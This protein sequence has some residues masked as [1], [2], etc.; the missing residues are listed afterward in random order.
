MERTYENYKS[1]KKIDN[2]PNYHNY[3]KPKLTNVGWEN[4][5]KYFWCNDGY[6]LD[7]LSPSLAKDLIPK[8]PEFTPKGIIN[9]ETYI[10]RNQKLAGAGNPKTRIAPV[11]AP[12]CLDLSYWKAN[13]LVTHSAINDQSQ[14]DEYQSGY[15]VMTCSA[16]VLNNYSFTNYNKNNSKVVVDKFNDYKENYTNID[17]SV[18]FKK[19]EIDYQYPFLKTK[20]GSIVVLPGGQGQ[21]NAGCGYNPEQLF[22]AELPANLPSGNVQKDPRMKEYN[23]N[24]FTQIIQPGVYTRNEVNEPINSNIGI[25]FTQQFE[26]LTRDTDLISDEIMYTEHDP[27]II[28]TDLFT[29]EEP[30][31][32]NEATESNIY[33]PRFTSYGTSYRSYTDDVVGQ[34]RFYYDDVNAIRM[35]NYI[36]RSNIDNQ[37]FADS[38]GPIQENNEFGNKYHSVI[39]DLANNAF[40]DN[41]LEFRNDLQERLMRK[42]NARAWQRRDAPINTNG[43]RMLGGGS[44]F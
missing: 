17:K 35:P 42:A 36:S 31:T 29:E 10:S 3:P 24:L 1:N 19:K 15:Q 27:R 20:K 14:I 13:N 6:N 28:D 39:R 16:P 2:I 32:E 33:D 7:G 11:I 5:A 41:S 12:P 18:N 21:V 22:S 40:L 38:Y 26:P 4:P 23:K 30:F 37:K 8:N 34:T 25:S 43:Q 44:R 9:N